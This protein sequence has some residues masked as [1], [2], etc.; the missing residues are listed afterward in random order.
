MNCSQARAALLTAEPEKLRGLGESELA[1]HVRECA[2]CNQLAS[3]LLD[4]NAM[5]A[6][7]LTRQ[8]HKEP[9]R[10]V[11]AT[12]TSPMW[13]RLPFAPATAPP[14]RVHGN[15][16]TTV[17]RVGRL[18]DVKRPVEAPVVHTGATGNVAVFRAA[19]NVTVVW[20]LKAGSGS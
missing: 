18:S 5:L 20:Q 15:P 10:N 12:K 11:P 7:Q 17:P 1:R 9:A 3:L 19:G 16:E 14:I 4:A 6:N 13:L 8:A 2:A